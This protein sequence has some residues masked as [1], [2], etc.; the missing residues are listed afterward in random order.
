[1][2]TS[3]GCRTDTH[4]IYLY[5]CHVMRFRLRI[6]ND[7]QANTKNCLKNT[8]RKIVKWK[9]RPMILTRLI[10]LSFTYNSALIKISFYYFLLKNC[11]LNKNVKNWQC[12]IMRIPPPP[13][14]LTKFVYFPWP[15]LEVAPP[16]PPFFFF[17]LFTRSFPP[18]DLRKKLPSIKHS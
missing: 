8:K 2:I 5:H 15:P 7:S 3:L 4:F 9:R 10:F 12:C 13:K 11:F 6:L 18:V 14:M 16:I 1:M 17:F